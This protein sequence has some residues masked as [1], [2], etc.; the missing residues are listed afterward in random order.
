M[1]WYAND[2]L[3]SEGETVAYIL[4]L[5]NCIIILLQWSSLAVTFGDEHEEDYWH[6]H[7]GEMYDH[8]DHNNDRYYDI[9]YEPEPE[10]YDNLFL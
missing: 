5:I 3:D 6:H 2:E 10:Y 1:I 7:Q 8:E 4:H 9:Y